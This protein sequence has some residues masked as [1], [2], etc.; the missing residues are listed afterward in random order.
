MRTVTFYS[1]KGG[2]GR[3]LALANIAEYLVTKFN[4]KVCIIDFDLEAPGM[5]YKLE[6]KTGTKVTLQKGIVDY[7]H[8]FF[9]ESKQT[10]FPKE[11]KDYVIPVSFPKHENNPI[12]YIPAGDAKMASYWQKLSKLEF[13]RFFIHYNDKL[14]EEI[15]KLM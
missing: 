5:N 15:K 14:I 8:Y 12:S 6:E 13:H 4:K 9:V 11:L 1:Y 10:A 3:T 2:V 7:M